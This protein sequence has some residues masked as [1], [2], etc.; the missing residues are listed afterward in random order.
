M[1]DVEPNGVCDVVLHGRQTVEETRAP[2]IAAFANGT[3]AVSRLIVLRTAG[4]VRKDHHRTSASS[5]TAYSGRAF[6][7]L[8]CYISA[9]VE[10]RVHRRKREPA[11]ET[12]RL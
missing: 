7:T 1:R 6:S 11:V 3:C 2:F 4:L 5:R 8:D 9:L 12:D 10:R